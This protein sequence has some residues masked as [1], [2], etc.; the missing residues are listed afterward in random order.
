MRKNSVE[1]S[2]TT[3][4][5]PSRNQGKSS[6][7]RLRFICWRAYCPLIPRISFHMY[8]PPSSWHRSSRNSISI[9]RKRKKPDLL[10]INIITFSILRWF[11]LHTHHEG[12]F[13][14]RGALGNKHP[15]LFIYL[16]GS[17]MPWLAW[18]LFINTLIS[19]YI[20]EII[21]FY[22]LNP[23]KSSLHKLG[24]LMS[25]RKGENVIADY[26]KPLG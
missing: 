20:S 26:F 17:S 8:S 16:I 11:S 10:F 2:F 18:I 5:R 22:S 14:L 13:T 7:P 6:W 15:E 1:S 12:H 4:L 3:W 23:S 19:F 21:C 9:V 24:R 25:I